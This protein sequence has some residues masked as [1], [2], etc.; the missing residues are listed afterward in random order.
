MRDKD[1]FF[2]CP[3]IEFIQHITPKIWYNIGRID[4]EVMSLID[5]TTFLSCLPANS[6]RRENGRRFYFL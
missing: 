4:K 3:N 6:F 2:L 1:A 5:K